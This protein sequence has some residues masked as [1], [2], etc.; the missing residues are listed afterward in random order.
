MAGPDEARRSQ[1][2]ALALSLLGLGAA[3]ASLWA[4]LAIFWAAGHLL[5]AGARALG[6]DG[7]ADLAGLPLFGLIPMGLTLAALPVAN[8]WSRRIERQADDSPLRT[9]A[10]PGART[11]ALERLGPLNLA[12][13]DPHFLKEL[14]LS[15]HPSISSGAGWPASPLHSVGRLDTVPGRTFL[16]PEA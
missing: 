7:P 13:L 16:T 1:N 15:S 8:A 2:W 11:A 14:L 6:L 10:N 3:A 5:R 12:E 9:A 4:L